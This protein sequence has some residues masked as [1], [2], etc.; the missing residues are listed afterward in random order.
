MKNVGKREDSSQNI[1]N[2][3][4]YVHNELIEKEQH[5][6]SEKSNSSK[7]KHLYKLKEKSVTCIICEIPQ[8]YH[9]QEIY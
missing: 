4:Q 6:N 8:N 2:T 1:I 9:H 3:I 5:L 7:F